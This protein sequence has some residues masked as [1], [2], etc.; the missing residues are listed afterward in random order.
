MPFPQ[1]VNRERPTRSCLP[2][3]VRFFPKATELLRG[4][5]MTG[6][7][8]NRRIS[9]GKVPLGRAGLGVNFWNCRQPVFTHFV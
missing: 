5:E 1:R 7:A 8:R 3:N 9:F 4:G 2:L 6:W